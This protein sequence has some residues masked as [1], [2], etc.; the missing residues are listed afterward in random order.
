[1]FK[2]KSTKSFLHISK[3]MISMIASIHN[4]IKQF[5]IFTNTLKGRNTLTFRAKIPFENNN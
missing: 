4:F 5:S 3:G 1:M 2:K